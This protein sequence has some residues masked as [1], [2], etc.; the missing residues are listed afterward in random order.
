MQ[1]LIAG[2][3]MGLVL[4]AGAAFAD[5]DTDGV[6]PVVGDSAGTSSVRVLP[7]Y[8]R[9]QGQANGFGGGL[10]VAPGLQL[11]FTLPPLGGVGGGGGG[12]TA[13]PS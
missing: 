4:P 1:K 7:A 13:S 5:G 2:V 10:S 12:G 6:S 8:F 3:V 9:S 11:P